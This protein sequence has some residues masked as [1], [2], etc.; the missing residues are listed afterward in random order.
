MNLPNPE[1]L[2]P[3]M[4]GGDP[5]EVVTN[6]YCGTPLGTVEVSFPK[7]VDSDITGPICAGV[8]QDTVTLTAKEASDN[9]GFGPAA[10]VALAAVGAIITHRV[11]RRNFHQA[12][13]AASH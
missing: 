12:V 13:S 3:A 8:A 4:S 11:R 6:I 10:I 7:P 1:V 5:G 9:I 2:P